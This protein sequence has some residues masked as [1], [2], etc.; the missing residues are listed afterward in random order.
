MFSP[1]AAMLRARYPSSAARVTIVEPVTSPPTT[2][3]ADGD[4]AQPILANGNGNGDATRKADTSS[5]SAPSTQKA[6]RM[7]GMFGRFMGAATPAEEKVDV[8][9]KSAPGDAEPTP[10]QTAAAA[11]A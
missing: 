9:A 1:L 6:S 7:G 5:A 3:A 8:L 11:A 4:V 10:S 2:P